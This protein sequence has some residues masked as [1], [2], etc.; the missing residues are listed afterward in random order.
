M[1]K[2]R[3]F[4]EYIDDKVNKNTSIVK[5]LGANV[6]FHSFVLDIH[7]IGEGDWCD[8]EI[9]RQIDG[10][11]KPMN[12]FNFGARVDVNWLL[13]IFYYTCTL[14]NLND[15]VLSPYLLVYCQTNPPPLDTL[16][17]NYYEDYNL[18]PFYNNLYMNDFWSIGYEWFDATIHQ[19]ALSV[20]QPNPHPSLPA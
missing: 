17:V 2:E 18:N 7:G 6:T 4:I 3:Q 5:V 12:F 1:N 11:S 16:I 13:N 8:G 10:P 14:S 20:Y 15:R 9:V 19:W